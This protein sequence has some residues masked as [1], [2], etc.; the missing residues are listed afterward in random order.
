MAVTWM[1]KY[2]AGAP[3]SYEHF[4]FHRKAFLI[5]RQLKLDARGVPLPIVLPY[6][7]TVSI[8]TPEISGNAPSFIPFYFCSASISGSSDKQSGIK[9][10]G[11]V[12]KTG[13]LP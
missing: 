10:Q 8:E 5:H 3:P 9:V 6:V 1:M 2:P 13:R 12:R 4:R 11:S 7:G